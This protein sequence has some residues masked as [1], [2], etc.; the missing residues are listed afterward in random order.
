MLLTYSNIRDGVLL[1]T[2]RECVSVNRVL[3][4]RGNKARENTNL[5]VP[6][7]VEEGDDI[8]STRQI[9]QN[10]DLALNLLLLD[11]LQNLDDAFL[12][13]LNVDSFKDFGI[14]PPP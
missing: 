9:L 13:V 5:C 11:R 4:H 12:I 3:K 8:R 1:Y 14:F 2:L 10:L 6:D 7:N